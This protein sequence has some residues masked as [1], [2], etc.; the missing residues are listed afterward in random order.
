MFKRSP[1][2]IRRLATYLPAVLVLMTLFVVSGDYAPLTTR[3]AGPYVVTVADDTVDGVC[4]AHC[5]L[6]DAMTVANTDGATDTIEFAI[7]GSGV[8]EIVL[9]S[10]LPEIT[11]PMRIFGQTQT[12]ASCASH[13]LTISIVGGGTATQ[14]FKVNHTGAGTGI[15]GLNIRN[16]NGDAII[17]SAG[18][19]HGV[20]CSNIGTN[21]A[22]T[23]AS[24]N[25]GDGIV[26][27]A[28]TSG[29][30]GITLGAIATAG[31]PDDEER[32]IISGN[33]GAGIRSSAGTSVKVS[34]N[35]I[36]TN[37]AGTAAIGNGEGGVI[38][39]AGTGLE[40]GLSG[41]N[42]GV[43]NLIS[44]NGGPG[45]T[46]SGVT[47]PQVQGNIIGLNAA[48]TSAIPN[49]LGVITS[50]PLTFIGGSDVADRNVISGNTEAGIVFLPGSASSGSNGNYVGTNAAG[51]AAIPNGAGISVQVNNISLGNSGAN[52]ISGNTGNA[53]N[54]G[55][56]SSNAYIAGNI[57]G[58]RPDGTTP[59]PN[60]GNGVEVTS[61]AAL[62]TVDV[63]I[64]GGP[65]LRQPFLRAPEQ[66]Q[67]SASERNPAH[68][69]AGRRAG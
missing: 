34:G 16:I 52:V 60:G 54:L 3:A 31:D 45:I 15:F 25:T 55:P 7:P 51:T 32:N 63:T 49:E 30:G 44:G 6:R 17:I 33:L 13:S 10:N 69:R 2:L 38:G 42:I 37:A 56:G 66:W 65:R 41:T 28:G 40:I 46:L 21:A 27:E 57:I 20:R 50:S 29:T 39:E 67:R 23:A 62:S 68:P 61:S 64:G 1:S 4:D 26:V 59:L 36:G 48:G 35:Y 53:I 19:L 22:G 43:G 11:T 58:Y 14:G 8:K 18:Q 5:S 9:T 12:G 47:N 24:P